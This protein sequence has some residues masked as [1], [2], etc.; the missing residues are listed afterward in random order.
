MK[1]LDELQVQ[2]NKLYEFL[3]KG[4]YSEE[5]FLQRQNILNKRKKELEAGIEQ[6][7]NCLPAAIDY[8]DKI[9]KYLMQYLLCKT[10]A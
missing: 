8:E 9:K 3:E 2:Q 10:S 5:I 1:E 4:I 7:Q 6:Q